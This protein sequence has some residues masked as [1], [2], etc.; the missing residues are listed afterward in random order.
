YDMPCGVE[1]IGDAATVVADRGNWLVKTGDAKTT[2]EA[3]ALAANYKKESALSDVGNH[4]RDFLSC[5]KTRETPACSVDVG[6]NVALY[7]HM[8][9]I[10]A[11]SGKGSLQWHAD[12]QSFKNKDVNPFIMPHYRKN[13]QL[14]SI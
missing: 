2:E 3:M 8:A 10:G 5:V 14:S 12:S 13:W 7:A 4:V 6:R 9:N 1:F 11:R